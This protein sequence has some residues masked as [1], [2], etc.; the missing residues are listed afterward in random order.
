MTAELDWVHPSVRDVTIDYLMA[1]DAERRRFL[2]TADP[3]GIVLALSS[4]GGTAG[5]RVAP[6][7]QSHEDWRCLQRRAMALIQAESLDGQLA[8]MRGML[9]LLL[10]GPDASADDKR[11]LREV[12]VGSLEEVVRAW[13]GSGTLLD[14]RALRAFFDL[15]AEARVHS[16]CPQLQSSWNSI[17]VAAMAGIED[18][19][20]GIFKLLEWLQY[21]ELLSAS[22]P[23]FLRSVNWPQSYKHL[24]AQVSAAIAEEC[25]GMRPLDPDEFESVEVDDDQGI[26]RPVE[27]SSEEGYEREWL[28]ASGDV[29]VLCKSLGLAAGRDVDPLLATVEEHRETRE[30]RQQ[31]YLEQDRWEPDPEHDR[32]R[33]RTTSVG[34]FDIDE[35]F[36]DL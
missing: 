26:E 32:D 2:E 22:E 14:Q 24:G 10:K 21:V 36:A 7:L 11:R 4:A 20:D 12:V 9:S 29:L 16:T 33:A 5:E 19:T 1:H 3:A 18:I 34:D 25:E 13:N 6:F 27:P 30:T 31:R 17:T 8:L 28:D 15:S 23:R 35:F